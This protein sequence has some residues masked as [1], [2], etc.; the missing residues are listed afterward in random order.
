[1]NLEHILTLN[2]HIPIACPHHHDYYHDDAQIRLLPSGEK[3][4]VLAVGLACSECFSG[5]RL[6]KLLQ[7]GFEYERQV[8]ED[9]MAGN[10]A[11]PLSIHTSA[12]VPAALSGF[13]DT[14]GPL[15]P[16]K[17]AEE[18][19]D[20]CVSLQ[21]E[22]AS[23]VW[24]G[25]DM[26]LQ[27]SILST[28]NK[29]RKMVAVGAQS[30]HGPPSTSFGGKSPLWHKNYQ[31]KYP[32]PEAG[33]PFDEEELLAKYSAFLETHADEIGV[34]LF[35]PQ[36]GSSQTGLV[37]PKDLLKKYISMAKEKGIKILCDEILCGLGRHGQG[38]LFLSEAWGL[39]PDCFTF[40]K[41]I[42]GGA[43][44]LS[45]AILKS[46][47][48]VLG[49]QG[50]SVMQSHTFAGSSARALMTGQEV[51]KE[52]TEYMPSIA[53]LGE[54]MKVITDYLTSLADGMLS[55][56]GHGLMWGCLFTHNGMHKEEGLRS[57]A[58]TT[59]RKH[60][61]SIGIIPY[62]VPVGGFMVTPCYD[63]DVGTIYEIGEKLEEAISLTM[64]EIGWKSQEAAVTVAR[65]M[66]EEIVVDVDPSIAN[67]KAPPV[68]DAIC[69]TAFHVYKTCTT[70]S[71]FVCPD[72]R[73]R[74]LRTTSA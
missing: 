7:P 21:L 54:E 38:T 72:K 62:F 4:E 58:I 55:F 34:M 15:L 67:V 41:A 48:D 3:E 52:I 20:W 14:L 22:G 36:W 33:V 51:L 53:K 18:N 23:A 57:K 46:G 43:F 6:A 27:V 44:P 32:V 49:G 1:M 64:K 74:F 42:G 24:A 8:M 45:G 5:P 35:E 30:Y 25:I 73:Q 69:N 26:L 63:T 66:P 59:F 65:P 50:R 71:S 60:C 56:Q 37:W 12:G 29:R 2:S 19:L 39:D 40:G 10:F 9:M 31:L 17:T 61:E 70:C 13:I 16:W 11:A 68:D 47:R 28:G